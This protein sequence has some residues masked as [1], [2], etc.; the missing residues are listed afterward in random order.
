MVDTVYSS[1]CF[2][3]MP[4][5]CISQSWEYCINYIYPNTLIHS[6]ARN[7]AEAG[8]TCCSDAISENCRVEIAQNDYCYCDENCHDEGDCCPDVNMTRCHSNGN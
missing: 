6:I 3:N 7:C 5:A 4:T 1:Y 2:L 8:K